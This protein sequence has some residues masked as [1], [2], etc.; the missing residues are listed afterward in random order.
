MTGV[1]QGIFIP[2]G[3]LIL[4]TFLLKINCLPRILWIP[5]WLNWPSV[6]HTHCT[7]VTVSSVYKEFLVILKI[8]WTT[9][10]LSQAAKEAITKKHSFCTWQQTKENLLI[11]KPN[12]KPVICLLGQRPSLHCILLGIL[13]FSDL[14]RQVGSLSR[15]PGRGALEASL[16]TFPFLLK[17]VDRFR[18]SISFESILEI[19]LF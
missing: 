7:E 10:N 12:V 6:G 9:F 15:R 4:L 14:Q 13:I 11:L 2:T 18:F 16:T 1:I 5:P 3:C 17:V 19:R 8:S